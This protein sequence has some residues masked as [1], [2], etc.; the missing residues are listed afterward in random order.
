MDDV[1]EA[2]AFNPNRRSPPSGR[3]IDALF[4]GLFKRF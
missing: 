1:D 3:T 2:A 4:I